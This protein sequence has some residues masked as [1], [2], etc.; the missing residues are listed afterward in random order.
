MALFYL[1]FVRSILEQLRKVTGDIVFYSILS[2]KKISLSPLCNIRLVQH[3]LTSG[4]VE[5]N[6]I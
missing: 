2:I 5:M 4:V 1:T 3:E 6:G